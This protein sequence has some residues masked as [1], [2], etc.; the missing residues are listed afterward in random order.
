MVARHAQKLARELITSHF[1]D[2]V[3]KVC[4]CLVHKG[5][6][7][8]PEIARFTEL[9]PAQLKNCLL[10]LIQHNCVQAFKIEQEEGAGPAAARSFTQYVAFIDSILHRMRFPKF[11]T[12]VR[13][14]LGEESESLFEGLLEHGRLTF[15]QIV[16][17]ASAQS[18]KG[19]VDVWGALKETF[20]GLVHSC[21]IER[22]PV[23][24][25]L[26]PPRSS[27]EAPKK[28]A[29]GSSRNRAAIGI[30]EQE[31]EERRII[32]AAAPL[33]GE[34]FL[35]P[36]SLGH[37]ARVEKENRDNVSSSKVGE[38]RKYECLK[39][40]T[41]QVIRNDDKEVLWRV[42]YEEVV[43]RLRHKACVAQ[44][45]S[46]L[47]LGAGTVLEAMLEATRCLETSVK[48]KI[49]APLSM[50]AIM[51]A[52]RATT[53]GRTMTLERIRASLNQMA[54]DSVG[55]LSR[56]GEV[57]GQ[58]AIYLS[59]ILEAAKKSE[60]EAIVLKRFGRE[61]CRV[62]RLL[63]MKGQLEQ[64]QISDQA[65]VGR[66]ET[67]EILYKLLKDEYLQ[68]QEIAKSQDHDPTRTF[69]LWRVNYSSLM[70]HIIDDMYHGASNLGQR[71][72]HELEQEQEVLD[73]L[74]QMHQSQSKN[75]DGSTSHV[76]L[77]KTQR[78]QVNHIRRVATVLET[79]ILKLDDSIML[80]HDF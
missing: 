70:E 48:Q 31:T 44:V 39:E 18:G 65:L 27:L 7:T 73:L 57:G 77:T 54:S 4:S 76:T 20:A 72:A 13:E 6:L 45:R 53:E 40:D 78:D 26:L 75:T 16:Q 55:Y 68:L 1:G 14:H 67:Q 52:V 32:A 62:F 10:V 56:T 60:V 51:Q 25:P 29:R 41:G 19:E 33:E 80:F 22:C 24:E 69:Y 37:A 38:K 74:K 46:R 5:T 58:Y 23:A 9:T 64:K 3:G 21:Y 59:K 49:S 15:E 71:L 28:G 2:I 79:S 36:S 66:R 34:R 12:L 43:R 8:V 30:A 47:D 63:A 61:S 11:L 35:L 17:R 50:D 42:N